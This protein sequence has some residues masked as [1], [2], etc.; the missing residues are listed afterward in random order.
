MNISNILNFLK[1]YNY[2]NKM[3]LGNLADGGY[4]ISHT[5]TGYDCYISA[6][7][8]DEESFTRD[9]INLYKMNKSNSFAFDGTILNYPIKY[10][11]N[12]NFIRKNIAPFSSNK[13]ANL[14]KLIAL[15]NNIFLK[16]DIEGAEYPWLLSLSKE[17]LQKFKQITIEFH[18]IN[19]NSWGTN[20]NDKIECFK[21]LAETHYL[22]HIHAN[23][24][25]TVTIVNG[26]PIPN[27]IEL[28][29][30]NKTFV[31]EELLPNKMPMP[32]KLDR[33][34]C[35]STPDINLC[36]RPFVN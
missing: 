33:P 26:T 21:K 23:N 24:Y 25:D 3:R 17:Q 36:F 13:T 31:N 10:T 11:R 2:G 19:D 16:M 35:K 20:Y 14:S 7:V 30:I 32:C 27:V 12:I 18:G 9:F 8:A 4:V 5:E 22:I 34:N 15:Y 1:V 28:T 29:Y 6:G